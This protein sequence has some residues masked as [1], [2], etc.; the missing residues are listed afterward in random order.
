MHLL[1]HD[2]G[3]A[4]VL[5]QVAAAGGG[6]PAAWFPECA[7]RLH[8]ADGAARLR[9]GQ[10]FVDR[11]VGKDRKIGVAT[12]SSDAAVTPEKHPKVA[13]T[14]D[15]HQERRKLVDVADADVRLA[16]DG[17]DRRSGGGGR[18]WRGV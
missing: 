17:G 4:D 3:A 5:V 15:V 8:E 9:H 12:A 10:E 11:L 2:A 14:D 7:L 13:V 6:Y 18:S 1:K 16:G